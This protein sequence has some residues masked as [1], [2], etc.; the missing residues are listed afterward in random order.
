MG[1]RYTVSRENITPTATQDIVTL[2]SA[3]NRRIRL[4]SVNVRGAGTTSAQ[5][6]LQI[7][8]NP[9]G[10]TPGGAIVPSKA[11]HSEQPAATFTT[12]TTWAAQPALATNF[13]VVGW[14]AL[15]GPG[16]WVTPPGRPNGSFEARNGDVISIRAP[17]GPTYQAMS[18]SCIVEED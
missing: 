16:R 18:L 11:E 3:A 17:T 15:G 10:T 8:M 9:T 4:I 5:Q 12:A 7:A 6:G 14:N 13:D 1:Q 2:I